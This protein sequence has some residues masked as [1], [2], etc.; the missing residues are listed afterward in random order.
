MTKLRFQKIPYT[1][2]FISSW[3]DQ[4]IQKSELVRLCFA[5]HKADFGLKLQV[6]TSKFS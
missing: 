1:S 5:K 6:Q 4:L 3:C 2:N